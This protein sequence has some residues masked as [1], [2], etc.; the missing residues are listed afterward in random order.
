MSHCHLLNVLKI[1]NDIQARTD[2]VLLLNIGTKFAY[3]T[4]H[5]TT[6]IHYCWQHSDWN[7]WDLCRFIC[8]WFS[9]HLH[10]AEGSNVECWAYLQSEWSNSYSE[11]LVWRRWWSKR[12]EVP[13]GTDSTIL[14]W[15]QPSRWWVRYCYYSS[16]CRL[17]ALLHT[18]CWVTH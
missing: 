18:F 6:Y 8:S 3:G 7:K 16:P 14:Y 17:F 10:T 5:Y 1:V 12:T 9:L 15:L 11:C 2:Q 4:D 13:S